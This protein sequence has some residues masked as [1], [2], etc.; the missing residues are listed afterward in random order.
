MPGQFTSARTWAPTSILNGSAIPLSAATPGTYSSA[1]RPPEQAEGVHDPCD[2]RP[3]HPP[4]RTLREDRRR[5]R[6]GAML[7]QAPIPAPAARLPQTV[8]GRAAAAQAH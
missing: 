5:D 8:E 4:D 3:E 6:R 1:V 7:G 2:D